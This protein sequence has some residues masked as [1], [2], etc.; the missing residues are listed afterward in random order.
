MGFER[1]ATLPLTA[2]P[3]LAPLLPTIHQGPDVFCRVEGPSEPGRSW[4]EPAIFAAKSVT[5]GNLIA[6]SIAPF[7]RNF[8]FA[9]HFLFLAIAAPVEVLSA[10]LLLDHYVNGPRSITL[11]PQLLTGKPRKAFAEGDRKAVMCDA[12][13]AIAHL[14]ISE[15]RE[16]IE[17][18]FWKHSDRDV[19]YACLKALREIRSPESIPFLQKALR[20]NH[21]QSEFIKEILNDWMGWR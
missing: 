17:K 9:D 21:E 15:F 5:V 2:Q 1:M 14:A 20:Q 7:L 8:S 4:V 13:E 10:F 12:L 3:H 16:P 19:Q 11:P 18:L 6:I